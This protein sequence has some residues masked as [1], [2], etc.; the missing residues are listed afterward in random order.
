M[1]EFKHRRY[2]EDFQKSFTEKHLIWDLS[3]CLVGWMQYIPCLINLWRNRLIRSPLW[4]AVFLTLYT[5][6]KLLPTIMIAVASGLYSRRRTAILALVRLVEMYTTD[7]Y[8][9]FWMDFSDKSSSFEWTL[10]VTVFA[11]NWISAAHWGILQPIPNQRWL[12]IQAIDMARIFLRR[13]SSMRRMEGGLHHLS[14]LTGVV[15]LMGARLG[16]HSMSERELLFTLWTILE[17]GGGLLVPCWLNFRMQLGSRR[18]W[19]KGIMKRRREAARSSRGNLVDPD[20]AVDMGL[21]IRSTWSLYLP[22]LLAF[23]TLCFAAG[24]NREL[25]HH[26][27]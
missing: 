8:L 15:N 11:N 18:L 9:A 26:M 22:E 1:M 3:V 14:P 6:E 12:A 24:H 13:S 21:Q 5:T 16:A 7:A 4:H 23:L 19:R 10:L 27:V 2:E 20:P 17:V 25:L